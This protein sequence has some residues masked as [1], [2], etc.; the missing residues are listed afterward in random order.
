MLLEKRAGGLVLTSS[1]LEESDIERIRKSGVPFVMVGRNMEEVDA[2]MVFTDYQMGGYQI[3]QHLIEIGHRRIAHIT[4]NPHHRESLEKRLGYEKALREAGIPI[5]D[6]YLVEGNNE[7]ESGYLGAKKLLKMEERP[8]AIFAGNDLMA[9][10]A[11]EA[12]KDSGLSIPEDI[13]VVGFDDINIATLIQPRLTTISQPVYKMGLIAARLLFENIENKE[14]NDFCQKIFIQ[15]KLMV[16][17]SC[18]H[19]DRVREIFN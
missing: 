1:R 9:I 7:M 3:T 16:R 11:M 8:H 15:P 18:G 19:E 13:G 10:G 14:E 4:G 17:K 6:H 5:L 2:N 12:I